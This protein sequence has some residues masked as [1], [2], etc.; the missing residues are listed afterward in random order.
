MSLR[1]PALTFLDFDGTFRQQTELCSRFPHRW[2]DFRDLHETDLYCSP[3]SFRA[4]RNA[5]PDT[6]AS[7]I[8]LIGCGNYHYVALALLSRIQRPFTLIL[9]DH[10]TDSTEAAVPELISCGSWV[11][12]AFLELPRLER[13][14]MTGQEEQA[15]QHLPPCVRERTVTVPDLARMDPLSLLARIPTHDIYLSI[16]KDAFAPSLAH[17]NW[18]QGSLRLDCLLPHL[19]AWIRERNVCGADICGELPASPI[20][21]L[22]PDVR[23]AIALNEHTNELLLETLLAAA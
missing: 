7:G 17:T 13:V 22:R 1:N 21:Q 10:H 11:Q 20:E 3:G 6:T 16:D 18:E 15:L 12:Q 5:L 2:L 23:S 9:V 4:I 14:I 8:T 19:R